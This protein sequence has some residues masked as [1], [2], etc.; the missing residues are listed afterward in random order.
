MS[1]NA[2][3]GF[4]EVRDGRI[5]IKVVSSRLH[6]T[7]TKRPTEMAIH[8]ATFENALSGAARPRKEQHHDR[9]ERWTF[10]SIRGAGTLYELLRTGMGVLNG[11]L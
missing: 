9:H 11:R 6:P 5:L 3:F 10:T 7:K 4:I 8:A 2:A 1:A